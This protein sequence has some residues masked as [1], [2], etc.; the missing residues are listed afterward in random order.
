[1]QDA[2]PM[3]PPD[4]DK[5]Y[6]TQQGDAFHLYQ[7]ENKT[8]FRKNKPQQIYNLPYQGKVI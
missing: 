4:S 3:L 5:Y 7:Y 8:M 6:M 1:M 2:R